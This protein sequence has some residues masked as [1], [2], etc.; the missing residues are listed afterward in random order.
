MLFYMKYDTLKQPCETLQIKIHY[1]ILYYKF[2]LGILTALAIK[3]CQH[4]CSRSLKFEKK[5][6]NSGS[7]R[8]IFGKM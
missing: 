5:C 7:D 8:S 3:S 6:L 2:E 4:M 1:Y